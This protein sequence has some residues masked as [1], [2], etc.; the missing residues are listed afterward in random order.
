VDRVVKAKRRGEKEKAK[1][2][3]FLVSFYSIVS[4]F[5]FV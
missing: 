2:T 1:Q 5:W 4:T 3:L